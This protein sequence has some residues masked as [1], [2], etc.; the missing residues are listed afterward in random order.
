MLIAFNKPYGVLSQFTSDGSNNDSL[1][2]FN[3]PPNVY[4]LGRLDAD[5]E[6]LLL[7]SDEKG[8][9]SSLLDPEHSHNRTYHVQVEGEI[10]DIDLL[11]IRKGTLIIQGRKV[12]SAKAHCIDNPNYPERTVPIRIR[13]SIPDSWIEMTLQE[14]KN[15]QVRRMTAAIGFPT[16][17][18]LRVAIGNFK[19]TDIMPGKWRE[20]TEQER[21]QIFTR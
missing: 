5:S 19:L 1:S 12:L 14:G 9:N 3:F 2:S 13:K 15:R 4:P 10:T 16:L 8:L 11:P 7:L 20:V 17:R 18:L 21:K 6:G